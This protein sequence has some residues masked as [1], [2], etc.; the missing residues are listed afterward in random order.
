MTP[1]NHRPDTGTCSKVEGVS[2]GRVSSCR[3]NYK[4]LVAPPPTSWQTV[5]PGTPGH[6]CHTSDLGGLLPRI[7][8]R[9]LVF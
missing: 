7:V 4:V 2:G 3:E 5:F 1:N 8:R 9:Q 6:A